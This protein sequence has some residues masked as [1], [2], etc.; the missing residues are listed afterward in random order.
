MSERC[1]T[2]VLASRKGIKEDKLERRRGREYE[3]GSD[4]TDEYAWASE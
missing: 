4:L 3:N 2:Y 1:V